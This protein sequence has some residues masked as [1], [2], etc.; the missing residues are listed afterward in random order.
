MF[1]PSQLY[2]NNGNGTFSDVT[3]KVLGATSWGAVGS[4]AFDFN[5]DGRLDLYLVDMHSD[6]W[7]SLDAAHESKPVALKEHRKKYEHV[8][9]AWAD[10]GPDPAAVMDKRFEDLFK[11]RRNEVI[12][13]NTFFKNRGGGKFDEI[14]DKA[15][16]ETFWPWGVAVGDF[17]NDGFEDVFI[18]SGMGHPFYYWP[19]QLMMNTGKET[20]VESAEDLGIEPP[21]RG[22]WLDEQI[23]DRR[24][25]RS[26]RSAAVADFDGDGRLD[27]VTNNF[28]DRPYYF[29]N[30]LPKKNHIAFR[31]TGARKEGERPGTPGSN[32]DAIGVVVRLHVGKEI[33]TRQVCPVGGYLAQSSKTLHFGLG[34]RTKVDYVEIHWP[35]WPPDKPQRI[36]SPEINTL[37]KHTEPPR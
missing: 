1:G 2:H 29:H 6:M 9:G 24:A 3:M 5:N 37:H 33:L 22:I 34:N 4:R 21:E 15:N 13:G 20:F 31:L 18:P 16:L 32:R 23:A 25:C 8:Y 14:S 7:M 35:G 11:Y 36:D 19:N 12:F 27:I 26:S 30:E 10:R 28:N 17:D